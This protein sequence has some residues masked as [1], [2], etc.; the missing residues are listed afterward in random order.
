MHRLRSGSQGKRVALVGRLASMPRREAAQLLRSHGAVVLERPDAT[1]HLVVVGEEDLPL[2]EADCWRIGST[3]R[4]G[5]A[6][7]QGTLEVLTETQF[8]QRLGLAE[9][10][11]RPPPALHARHAGRAAAACRVAV[12]RRWHRRGLIVPA[13][14]VRRLPY[15]D[16]H[17]V[18]TARRLA[19]LLAAGVSPREIEKKLAALARLVPGVQRPLA[20]LSVIIQGKEILLRQG[21]GLIEPGGQLR[22]DFEAWEGRPRGWAGYASGSPGLV[23]PAGGGAGEAESALRSRRACRPYPPT[24]LRRMAAEL[25]EAGQLAEAADMYRAAMAAAG[26][27]PETCFQ[28]A[29]LLY[30]LGDL[31]AARER[32]YMAIELDEDYVEAR[33]NLGCVLAETG[34]RELAVAAF[35]G[36]LR[37][38]ARLCRR[39]LPPGPHA[40]RNGPP[41]RGRGPLADLSGHGPRQPLGAASRGCGWDRVEVP[42]AGCRVTCLRPQTLFI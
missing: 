20:Q 17:E 34:Q 27:D 1:A 5:K 13:R 21:D 7:E 39:P 24:Q 23:A 12:I 3:S 33:A 14:E 16:F 31:A 30:R 35:E 18:A 32:Y 8:W 15:F 22:F 38:H 6:V 2:P 11:P 26:P 42:G 29:E 28:L 37:Y 10:E 40:G 41:R 4:C 36:A 9:A 19:E 25:E